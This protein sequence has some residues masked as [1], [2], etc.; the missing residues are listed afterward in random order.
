MSVY[1]DASAL[2]KRYVE[3]AG[4]AR[5]R[6][7]LGSGFIATSRLSEVEIASAVV[8]RWRESALGEAGRERILRTLPFDLASMYIVELSVDVSAKTYGLLLRQRLRAGD[9]IQLASCLQ[10]QERLGRPVR[11]VGFDD[12]LNQAAKAEGLEVES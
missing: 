5:V 2:V 10:L 9:A 3:E 7:L 11:F 8:R 6:D 12:R 1:F 4:S